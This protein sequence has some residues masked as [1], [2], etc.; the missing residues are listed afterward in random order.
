MMREHW[1]P[2]DP[3]TPFHRSGNRSGTKPISLLFTISRIHLQTNQDRQGDWFLKMISPANR[4]PILTCRLYQNLDYLLV[5][6]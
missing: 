6:S 3:E 2:K 4:L 1:V 5:A